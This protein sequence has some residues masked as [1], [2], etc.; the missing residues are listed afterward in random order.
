MADIS[1]QCG[2]NGAGVRNLADTLTLYRW[3]KVSR[4]VRR[5]SGN[6]SGLL[7]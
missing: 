4:V 6:L 5:T 1:K 2:F 3:D 7:S